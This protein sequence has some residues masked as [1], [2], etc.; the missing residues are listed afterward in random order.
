LEDYPSSDLSAE[1]EFLKPSLINS[2]KN[3]TIQ[4]N[5]GVLKPK[6]SVSW[7]LDH[8]SEL[9]LRPILPKNVTQETVN[10]RFKLSEAKSPRKGI[11][12]GCETGMQH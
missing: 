4:P 8:K 12:A 10:S 2:S 1:T 9:G 6:N 11:G 3:R 7:L 5:R